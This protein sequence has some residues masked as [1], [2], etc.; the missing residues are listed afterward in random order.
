MARR[1]HVGGEALC[2]RLDTRTGDDGNLGN[3]PALSFSCEAKVHPPL[4]QI[5]P[6]GTLAGAFPGAM[7]PL[8]GWAASGNLTYPLRLLY[9]F[10]LR[11]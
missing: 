6:L 4:K 9:Y 5:T 7:P 2:F 11:F 3:S 1:H 10:T 8:I